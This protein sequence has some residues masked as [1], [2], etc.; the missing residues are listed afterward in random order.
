MKKKLIRILF[1]LLIFTNLYLGANKIFFGLSVRVPLSM[2]TLIFLLSSNINFPPKKNMFLILL[3]PIFYFI[4]SLFDINSVIIVF[5]KDIII[6]RFFISI[7]I[8]IYVYTFVEIITYKFMVRSLI[9]F[10]ALNSIIIIGQYF[11]FDFIWNLTALLAPD[12]FD[13]NEIIR[14]FDKNWGEI[15]LKVDGRTEQYKFKEANM[16]VGNIIIGERYC[17]PQGQSDII[18]EQSGDSASIIFKIR[19][20]W[21]TTQAPSDENSVQAIIKNK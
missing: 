7:I 12:R 20:T 15:D 10:L 21:S 13:I 19:D 16:V 6:S 1:L 17:E 8:A 11:N 14:V 18:C 2:I 4:S 3:I 5:F 9:F